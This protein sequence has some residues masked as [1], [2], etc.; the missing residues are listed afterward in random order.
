LFHARGTA[1]KLKLL[2]VGRVR[3]TDTC[4]TPGVRIQPAAGLHAVAQ[5]I[6]ALRPGDRSRAMT[7]EFVGVEKVPPWHTRRNRTFEVAVETS[8]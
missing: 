1:V 2:L 5:V 3:V 7:T 8:T 6:V 4:C